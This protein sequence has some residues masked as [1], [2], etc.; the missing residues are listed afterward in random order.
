MY[1]KLWLPFRLAVIRQCPSILE[2]WIVLSNQ[3]FLGGYD[4]KVLFMS[5]AFGEGYKIPNLKRQIQEIIENLQLLFNL[6][7]LKSLLRNSHLQSMKIVKSIIWIDLTTFTMTK[8]KS[9]KKVHKS[10]TPQSRKSR[11]PLK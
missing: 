6:F 11:K 9:I 7:F 10:S 4:S 1:V 5:D 8:E 3:P 2:L